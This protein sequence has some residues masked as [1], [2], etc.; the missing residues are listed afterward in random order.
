MDDQYT[1]SSGNSKC[2][3]IPPM[4][5]KVSVGG[6]IAAVL[7]LLSGMLCAASVPT[8]RMVP[9]DPLLSEV[10]AQS[11][12]LTFYYVGALADGAAESAHE[13]VATVDGGSAVRV[14]LGE[15]RRATVAFG[16]LAAEIGRAHV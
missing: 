7:A 4:R 6:H 8:P 14:K 15:D 12:R 5:N 16:A 11:G 3:I 2:G 13:V 10:D 1:R 9:V